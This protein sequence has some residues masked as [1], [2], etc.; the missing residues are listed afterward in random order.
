[1]PI[2]GGK[3]K[4]DKEKEKRRQPSPEEQQFSSKEYLASKHNN[5]SRKA[6]PG[7]GPA[8]IHDLVA[9][10]PSPSTRYPKRQNS[11][12]VTKREFFEKKALQNS[13]DGNLVS[14]EKR[15]KREDSSASGSS[16]TTTSAQG[17]FTSV[18]SGRR[19]QSRTAP[20]SG[21][22][23][24]SEQ[25][26]LTVSPTRRD[27]SYPAHETIP[28][29]ASNN[30]GKEKTSGQVA[31]PLPPLL[32]TTVEHRRVTA[33]KNAHAPGG[34]FGFILRKSYLPVP[35]DPDKTKLVHLIEPRS[36][37][38]GPLMTGD[39]IIEVNGENVDNAPHE[40][41]VDLIKASGDSVDLLVASMPELLELNMR[42]ALDD[43]YQPISRNNQWRKSGRAKQGTGTLR[44][45]AFARK[46][47]KVCEPESLWR[48]LLSVGKH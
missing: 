45:R 9:Y 31:L 41:V 2:F 28:E 5:G 24:T 38:L 21:A 32:T 20:G 6:S 8:S 23:T 10:D 14:P 48:Y 12:V 30:V 34:G 44:K 11:N 35:E 27:S 25:S 46:A 47:F 43:Q 42:G 4:K 22:S 13:T 17:S 33:V 7:P 18:T 26:L 36:D 37:Y 3:K 1:M 16:G 40:R 15:R 39:R 19:P 29:Y